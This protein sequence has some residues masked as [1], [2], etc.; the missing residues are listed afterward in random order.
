MHTTMCEENAEYGALL[1]LVAGTVAFGLTRSQPV[2]GQDDADAE[3]K[4]ANAMSAAPS[5]IA[6]NATILDNKLDDD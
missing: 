5:T 2:A 4:I 1:A 3:A 6:D